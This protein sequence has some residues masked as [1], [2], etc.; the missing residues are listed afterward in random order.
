VPRPSRFVGTA[1]G[2]TKEIWTVV[3][4]C[5]EDV[6]CVIRCLDC[7]LCPVWETVGGSGQLQGVYHQPNVGPSWHLLDW[8]SRSNKIRLGQT[9]A[10]NGVPD[11]YID[12]WTFDKPYICRDRG[13]P[14]FGLETRHI[15]QLVA[16]L[17][18]QTHQVSINYPYI[19]SYTYIVSRTSCATPTSGSSTPARPSQPPPRPAAPS[20]LPA[21]PRRPPT[22]RSHHAACT[23]P[24]TPC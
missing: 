21:C 14:K 20:P 22:A 5:H 19:C 24:S 4:E 12:R 8:G 11:N 15:A 1:T 13:C 16:H 3:T 10:N 18:T 2:Q 23:C 6:D 17:Q 9:Y 7:V